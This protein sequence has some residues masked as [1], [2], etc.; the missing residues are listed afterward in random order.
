MLCGIKVKT[1]REYLGQQKQSEISGESVEKVGRTER[2]LEKQMI[3]RGISLRFDRENIIHRK[4]I[5]KV[6]WG[7]W[8]VIK[9]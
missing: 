9:I 3:N 5:R 1:L 7:K 4:R 8:K 6:Y 2:R